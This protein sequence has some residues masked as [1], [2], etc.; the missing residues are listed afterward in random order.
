MTTHDF[1]QNLIQIDNSYFSRIEIYEKS[2]NSFDTKNHNDESV[3]RLAQLFTYFKR[4][5]EHLKHHRTEKL[6]SLLSDWNKTSRI[7]I[8]AHTTTNN[9]WKKR[10]TSEQTARIGPVYNRRCASLRGQFVTLNHPFSVVFKMWPF[11]LTN[12]VLHKQLM[13]EMPVRRCVKSRQG[14]LVICGF[15]SVWYLG[16]S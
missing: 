2:E 8:S 14:R 10:A 5:N 6:T 9:D 13:T 7:L 16:F 3:K 1:N 12:A 15:N 11:L 4:T